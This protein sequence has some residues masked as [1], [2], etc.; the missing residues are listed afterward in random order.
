METLRQAITRLYHTYSDLVTEV[1]RSMRNL[2]DDDYI[3]AEDYRWELINIKNELSG[4]V[5]KK[6]CILEASIRAYFEKRQEMLTFNIDYWGPGQEARSK[7]YSL[8]IN[9]LERLIKIHHV[10]TEVFHVRPI[11][12][13]RTP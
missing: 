1:G 4:L 12:I 8:I 5:Y 9:D 6:D 13:W 7:V 3:K 2:H 10:P 11:M